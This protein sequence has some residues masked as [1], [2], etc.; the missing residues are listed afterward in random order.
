MPLP[1]PTFGI[2]EPTFDPVT[3]AVP[4]DVGDLWRQIREHQPGL[5]IRLIPAGQQRAV[6]LA[7]HPRETVH[8]STPPRPNL[9]HQAGKPAKAAFSLRTHLAGTIDAQERMPPE[10]YDMLVEPLGIQPAI[11][12]HDHHPVGRHRLGQVAQ[13]VLPVRLPR[14]GFIAAHDFP[15]HRN[16][17]ATVEHTDRQHR[18]A[19][20]QGAGVHR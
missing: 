20:R 5:G 1:A 10:L 3:H 2:F 16:G 11:S 6:H 14:A 7:L 9:R 15:G 18:E 19:I 13:Q 4:H 17:A 8:D 12:Q